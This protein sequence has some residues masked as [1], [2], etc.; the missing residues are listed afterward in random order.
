MTGGKDYT[1]LDSLPP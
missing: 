1:I